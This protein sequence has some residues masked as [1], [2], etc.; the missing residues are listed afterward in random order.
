[1]PG[2]GVPFDDEYMGQN[3]LLERVLASSEPEGTVTVLDFSLKHEDTK[4]HALRVAEILRE[5][6]QPRWACVGRHAL[7]TRPSSAEPRVDVIA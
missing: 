7:G 4:G 6:L 1:M 3:A 2:A 5:Y